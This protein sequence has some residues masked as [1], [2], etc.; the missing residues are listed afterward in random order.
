M[1]SPDGTRIATASYDRAARVFD[2][3]TGA[4]LARL[5]HDDTV[6]GVVFSPDGMRIA[7]ASNQSARVFDS[8]T[9]AELA[10]LN[11]DDRIRAVAFSPGG[12]HVATASDDHS[13]RVSEVAPDLLVRRAVALMTRPLDDRELRRYSLPP[14]CKHIQQWERG[15]RRTT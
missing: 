4:Q 5:N 14:D 7:T 13:A 8:V 3:M 12:A 9:G 6:T 1:Y 10:R 2:S 15:A 11:H